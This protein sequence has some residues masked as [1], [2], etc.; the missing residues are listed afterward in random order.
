[1]RRVRIFDGFAPIDGRCDRVRFSMPISSH[2][3]STR[4]FT[5]SSMTIGR[6]HSRSVSPGHLLVASSPIFEPSP[7]TGDA[8]SR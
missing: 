5:A 7:A 2:S 3:A 8:K 4:R 1:M 6:P